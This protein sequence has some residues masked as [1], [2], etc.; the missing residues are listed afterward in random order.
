MRVLLLS[1][2]Y[3]RDATD[4]RGTFIRNMANSIAHA[5]MVQLSIWAPPGELPES[6]VDIATSAETLWLGKLMAAGGIS[7]LIRSGGVRAWLAPFTLLR[8]LSAVYRRQFDMDIYH[9]NWLQ[10]A[11]PLPANGKPALITALGNDLKLLRLPLVRRLLRRAMRHRQVAICPNAEWM[12]APLQEAFGDVATVIPVSF[13]ID[14]RWYAIKRQVPASQPKRW[15][16]VT[17]LTADKLGPLFEWSMHC[18]GDGQREL[19]LFGPMQENI[20]I[21]AWV[22]YHGA[23]SP[24]RLATEWMPNACGLVTLSRHAEGCPQVILEAMAAGLPV[25]ASDMPAHAALVAPGVTGELCGS[26]EGYLQALDKLEDAAINQRFGEA[27]R[28]MAAQRFGTWSDCAQ[29]Y[30]AIYRA[31]LEPTA[32]G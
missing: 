30:T 7:H 25:I 32:N 9:V 18:F 17:R 14:D 5:D 27:A 8:M 28:H 6:T 21:P 16:A 31:L 3:P 13:G 2:T 29:R 4:W 1:T 19:H 23:A 12:Q 20:D 10:C 26:P 11:L 15:L 24:D 22:H